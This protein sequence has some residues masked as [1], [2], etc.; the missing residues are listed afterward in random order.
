MLQPNTVGT[1]HP[2]STALLHAAAHVVRAGPDRQ[3][4]E[5]SADSVT[6]ERTQ[7]P[8]PVV[9]QD[10]HREQRLRH[11]L[12]HIA[13]RTRRGEDSQVCVS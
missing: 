13:S 5:G 11:D 12:P 7:L 9:R 3:G 4:R 1:D 8:H 6:L 10:Q 2:A